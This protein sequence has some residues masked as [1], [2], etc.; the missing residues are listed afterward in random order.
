[1][2]VIESLEDTIGTPAKTV[3]RL[4]ALSKKRNVSNY[5][6]AGAVSE[7]DLEQMLKLATELR[8]QVMEWLEMNYPELLK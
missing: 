8:V 1:M 4:L 3:H 6:I 7:Q 2:R 5:D